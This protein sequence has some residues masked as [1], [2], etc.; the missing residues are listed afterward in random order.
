MIDTI[1]SLP[2]YKTWIDIFYVLVA[3]YAKTNNF[4]IGPYYNIASYNKVEGMRVRLGGRTS[5]KFSR[6][7]ELNGYV[8]YGTLDEKY[9]YSL[10]A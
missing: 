8:A 10:E 3:G 6:W 4:E 9:K 2:I 5:S 7:Y 1:Q